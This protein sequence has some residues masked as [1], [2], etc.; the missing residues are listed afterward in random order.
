V[1]Q[2]LLIYYYVIRNSGGGILSKEMVLVIN[3]GSTSTKVA[4]F[5]GNENVVGTSLKHSPEELNKFERIVDQYEYRRDM[6]IKWVE[7]EGH[8]LEELSCVVGR[9]GLLRPISSG[10]Y[11]VC[12]FMIN[13]LRIGYQGEHASNLGGIISRSIADEIGVESL[14]VDPV[15][16]DEFKDVARISGLKEITRRSLLHALNIKAKSYNVAKA[17][18][19]PLEEINM[20]VAHL[21][22]GISVVPIEKG[23]MIDTNNANEM[24]PFSPERTG[25]LP[26]GDLIRMAYSGKYTESQLK[27]K[28]KGNG[29][30][31]SYLGTNDAVEIERMIEEGNEYAKLVY[32]AM[33]YQ[34]AKEIGAMATVLMGDVQ[35]I[36]LTGGLAYSKHLVNYIKSM[37]NFIAP[38]VIEAG[39]DEMDALNQGAQRALDNK[40]LIKDYK[41]EVM[42]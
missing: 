14:I 35:A 4:L 32:E 18:K 19:T 23:K 38:V 9:G 25:G 31:T 7:E 29:G 42:K 12:D 26:V 10:I 36:V 39:E 2:K 3:P 22:G 16:V 24:G 11:R 41:K 8:L 6:I 34:I 28:I 15:S 20:V 17:M 5:K 21:G 33:A 13:D 30:L 27:K 1:A 40:D 37:V